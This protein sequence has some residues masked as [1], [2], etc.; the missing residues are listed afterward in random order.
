MKLKEALRKIYEEEK[1]LLVGMAVLLVVAMALLIFSLVNL[2]AG[3]ALVKV[4]YGDIGRYQG[5]EWSSM[6]NA[7]GYHD[8][9]WME[10][11]AYPILALIFGVF[12][13]LLAVKVYEKKG[14]GM[15]KMLVW[16]SVGLVIATFILLVRLLGEG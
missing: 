4:G 9:T 12:N 10:M 1:G 2:R 11:F 8:G 14:A 16:F 7:G 5:G 3:A 13:N 6:M 15:A